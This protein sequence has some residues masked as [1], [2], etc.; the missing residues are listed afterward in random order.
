MDKKQMR[1][2][3]I[4]PVMGLAALCATRCANAAEPI[5]AAVGA[6]L[7]AKTAWVVAYATPGGK[8]LDNRRYEIAR[9]LCYEPDNETEILRVALSLQAGTKLHL[10]TAIGIAVVST[11]NKQL[12]GRAT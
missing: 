10:N 12:F 3:M 2:M 5:E 8:P 9:A 6:I 7:A 1:H 11:C 4:L